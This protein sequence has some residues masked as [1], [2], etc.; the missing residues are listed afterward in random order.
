M[1]TV[2]EIENLL[3]ECKSVDD[4]TRL[5]LKGDERIGVMRLLKKHTLRIEKSKVKYMNLNKLRAFDKQFSDGIIVGIDEAGRG[6]LAGDVVAS[7]VV[8][9]ESLDLTGLDDSKKLTLSERERLRTII[10]NHCEVGIGKCSAEEIDDLNIYQAT[11][12]AMLR[13]LQD[14]NV[15]ADFVLL[16]AMNIDIDTPQ[17]KVIKGD[18]LSLSI[19]AASIIAKTTRDRDMELYEKC[20]PGY[21]FL[22]HKGYGTKEHLEALQRY[23]PCPIHRKT[24]EPVK[25]FV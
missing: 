4:I 19:A 24:F 20:Y 12:L 7:A 1:R 25:S 17:E 15:K 3:A 10:L 6:P 18:S 16:D 14:L 23:G 11:R 5:N 21:G 9:P 13:A 22:N 2:K 8:V